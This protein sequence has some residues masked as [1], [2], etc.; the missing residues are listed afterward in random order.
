MKTT[1]GQATDG[2]RVVKV[3]FPRQSPEA[4]A[5]T[6]EVTYEVTFPSDFTIT[7]TDSPVLMFLSATRTDTRETVT[8]DADEKK[9]AQE[10][11]VNQAAK[12]VRAND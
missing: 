5:P 3:E 9:L 2:R 7:R 6:I 4:D 8:L 1:P 10:A 11:A 12:M